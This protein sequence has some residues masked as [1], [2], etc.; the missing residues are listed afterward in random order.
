MGAL[1]AADLVII[2]EHLVLPGTEGIVNLVTALQTHLSLRPIWTQAFMTQQTPETPQ[3]DLEL[4]LQ[5][6]CYQFKEGMTSSHSLQH[7]VRLL[8]LQSLEHAVVAYMVAADDG[9]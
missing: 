4:Q 2:R 7:I 1:H 8:M 9:R 5:K 3:A 6:L